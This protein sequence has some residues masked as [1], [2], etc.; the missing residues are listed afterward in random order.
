MAEIDCY[1]TDIW[2]EGETEAIHAVAE[3]STRVI[4]L[5]SILPMQ[6]TCLALSVNGSLKV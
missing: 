5:S 1:S 2:I 4:L 3:K 6:W